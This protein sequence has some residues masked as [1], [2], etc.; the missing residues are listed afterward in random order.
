MRT[1][2]G[3]KNL[4]VF[5]D[6]GNSLLNPVKSLAGMF[7]TMFT[8]NALASASVTSVNTY[9][10]NIQ[11]GYTKAEQ[12]LT[13]DPSYR[14][15]DNQM[16]LEQSG[17]EDEI[18]SKYGKCFDGSVSIGNMI[19][20]GLIERDAD[21]NVLPDKGDCSPKNLSFNNPVYG[22]LVFR[23]R[24]AQSYNNTL[25]Q[26]AEMQNSGDETTDTGGQVSGDAVSLAKQIL[27]LNK[28]GKISFMDNGLKSSVENNIQDLADGKKSK[29]NKEFKQCEPPYSTP[30]NAD[31]DVDVNL[32]KF[33]VDLGSSNKFTI[34]ALTGAATT[35]IQITIRVRPLI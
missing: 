4:N 32:L 17:K 26:L 20:N 11:F 31:T 2:I 5:A 18:S 25:D 33:L 21:G 16:I 34:N 30:G 1:R 7:G 10:G 9:Y 15:L 27:D 24:V 6:I 23:W 12:D 28:A 29:T 14:P 3:A 13:E 19:Q 22:D 35:L 8:P